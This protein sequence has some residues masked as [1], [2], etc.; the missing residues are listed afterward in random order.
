MRRVVRWR[1]KTETPS[2]QGDAWSFYED[3]GEKDCGQ[4]S[5]VEQEV[6]AICDPRQE[7]GHWSWSP[8]G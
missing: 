8:S 2:E 1:R 4:L 3:L 6:A 5:R 7:V